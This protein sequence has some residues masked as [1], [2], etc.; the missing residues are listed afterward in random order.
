MNWDTAMVLAAFM[1]GG[2]V[3]GAS[4]RY[5]LSET[6]KAIAD[7]RLKILEDRE[8]QLKSFDET[9]VRA[10]LCDERHKQSSQ[11]LLSVEDSVKR[12]NAL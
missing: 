3:A 4:T 2:G 11:R 8:A 9:Y 1:G 6:R 12:R 7:L 5:V 10:K